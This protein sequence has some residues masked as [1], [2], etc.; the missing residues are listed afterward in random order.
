MGWTSVEPWCDFRQGYKKFI[1]S[2]KLASILRTALFWAITQQVVA[3]PCRRFGTNYLVSPSRVKNLVLTLEC[4]ATGYP[5]T[6]VRNCHYSLRNGSEERS[7][8]LL[9][10]GGLKTRLSLLPSLRMSEDVHPQDSRSGSEAHPASEPMDTRSWSR[11]LNTHRP[12]L[13]KLRMSGAMS[14]FLHMSSYRLER[15]IYLYLNLYLY[16][17][18]PIKLS[19]NGD[20]NRTWRE[21]QDMR[22]P[23]WDNWLSI[24]SGGKLLQTS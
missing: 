7:S 15:Q 1:S 16:F 18:K 17:Y 4:G 23:N 19:V 9:R 21:G 12:P 13:P 2:R 10:G 22:L 3:I 20:W 24:R 14:P 5:E 8:H 6:S 11:K